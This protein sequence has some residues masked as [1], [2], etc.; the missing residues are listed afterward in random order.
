[1]EDYKNQL[2]NVNINYEQKNDFDVPILNRE[3]SKKK[4]FEIRDEYYNVRDNY[5][6]FCES[7]KMIFDLYAG[8]NVRNRLAFYLENTLIKSDWDCL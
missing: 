6:S 7:N 3:Y 5:K 8:E 2:K 4:I 1:M